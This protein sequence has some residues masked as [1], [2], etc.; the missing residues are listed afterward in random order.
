MQVQAIIET[1]KSNDDSKDELWFNAEGGPHW[2]KAVDRETL[3]KLQIY[4]R[5]QAETEK[6]TLE[7][8][9]NYFDVGQGDKMKKKTLVDRL[10]E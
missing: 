4:E 3:E 7:T 10:C 5:L 6:A 1:V 9:Y 8:I 2:K